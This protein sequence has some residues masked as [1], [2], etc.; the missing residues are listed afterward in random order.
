MAPPTLKPK[1]LLH[2]DL[3]SYNVGFV[4]LEVLVFEGEIHWQGGTM[5][6]STALYAEMIWHLICHASL[7]LMQKGIAVTFPYLQ[8]MRSKT[9]RGCQKPPV[10]LKSSICVLHTNI[11]D[12]PNVKV[13]HSNRLTT[14]INQ[15]NYNKI[16]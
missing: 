16:L 7:A 15:N 14:I 5:M 3:Q 8:G 12:K 2:A 6:V 13:S 9:P 11:Y 1:N 4:N 10:G